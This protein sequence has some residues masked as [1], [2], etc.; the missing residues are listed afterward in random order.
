MAIAAGSRVRPGEVVLVVGGA[1]LLAGSWVIVA[2]K[3]D[4][5]PWEESTFDALNE[6]PD[7]LWWVVWGP[8][9][10]GSLAG[11][12]V[13]V[14][15]IHMVGRNVRLTLAA[16]AASLVVWW[17]AKGIKTLVSR[18]RP[19][20]LLS[21]VNLREHA[22]GLGYVSGHSAVAFA[23]AAVLAPSVP[24]RWRPAVYGAALVVALAR[25]YSGAHL[26]LDVVGG[27]G[28]GVLA[29]TLS[30]WT[31]GLGGEGLPPRAAAC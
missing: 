7:A 26:P 9:Q 23:L 10:L 19:G 28:L 12:L 24:A 16:L 27:A 21:R 31:F 5:P 17:S 2:A 30:R 1:A 8:M 18:G 6:L 4:V 20:A 3:G 11:S 22:S 14:A 25:V 15:I 13:V 29:G